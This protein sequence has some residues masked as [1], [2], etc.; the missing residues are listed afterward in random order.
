MSSSRPTPDNTGP[1]A[2]VTIVMAVYDGAAYLPGMLDSLGAQTHRDWELLASDDGSRDSSRAVLQRFAATRPEGQM[3]IVAGPAQGFVANFLTALTRLDPARPQ[4]L[5]FAD[6]D[7]VWMPQR[8]SDGLQALTGLNRP[9]LAAGPV[10]SVRSDLTGRRLAG[11]WRGAASFRNALVQNI[12]QGNTMLANPAATRLLITAAQRVA[13]AGH[14]PVSHDWWAYQIVTGAG[15]TMRQVPT[16]GLLYRQHSSNAI[17]VNA[18]P[19]AA[20]RRLIAALG[21]ARSVWSA[22]NSAALGCCATL[23]TPEAR[24]ALDAFDHLR[25]ARTPWQRLAALHQLRPRHQTRTGTVAL[26]LAALAGRI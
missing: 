9:A 6:Q 18:G 19:R 23:L 4:W 26:W 16:P 22:R 3:R 1:D 8:L 13:A 2:R 11:G 14:W 10:W 20:L 12:V 15:G 24:T 7:D 17:G 21:G 5:A 25:A